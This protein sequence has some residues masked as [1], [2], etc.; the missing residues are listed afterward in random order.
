[1]GVLTGREDA[2][3]E[4]AALSP[5]NDADGQRTL[6]A[7]EALPIAGERSALGK[8]R[9]LL[10]LLE[11]TRRKDVY[12]RLVSAERAAPEPKFAKGDWVDQ[13]PYGRGLVL[14]SRIEGQREIVT[15]RFLRGLVKEVDASK[16][17]LRK[18]R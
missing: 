10:E 6:L 16:G 8:T 15:I 1:L 3:A 7:D 18:V 17:A 14:A 13:S 9:A 5:G 4:I 11:S 2:G 12:D